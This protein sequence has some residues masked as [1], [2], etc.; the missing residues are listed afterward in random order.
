MDA[1]RWLATA[2]DLTG[3]ARAECLRGLER[4]ESAHTAAR[5]SVL[6]AFSDAGDFEN[7]GH[8]SARSWLRWQTRVTGAAAVGAVG[9][10]RRL[11]SHPAVG[12]ALACGEVSS[13]WARQICDWTDRLPDI[14]RGA[15]T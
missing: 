1:L 7:D 10:M 4:V 6:R 2:G 11:A 13:S 15:R 3:A 9:W 12:S 14:A 5:A 8:R